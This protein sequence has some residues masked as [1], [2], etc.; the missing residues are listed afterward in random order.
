MLQVPY[1]DSSTNMVRLD[2]NSK[3]YPFQQLMQFTPAYYTPILPHF[4]QY[5]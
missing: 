1:L 5:I 4:V 2:W 3:T